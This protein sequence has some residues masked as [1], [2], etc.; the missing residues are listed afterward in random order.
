MLCL[1]RYR[2]Q[3]CG[4]VVAANVV[5]CGFVEVV[6]VVVVVIVVVVVVV[7]VVVDVPSQEVLAVA[8]SAASQ[9]KRRKQKHQQC[10]VV[11][12]SLENVSY[13]KQ[14]CFRDKIEVG[15]RA[16][17]DCQTLHPKP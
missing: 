14:F 2:K 5:S 3:F 1:V 7:V 8:A 17:P 12:K 11:S 13:C 10:H 6:V 4:D 16:P 15:F 9:L